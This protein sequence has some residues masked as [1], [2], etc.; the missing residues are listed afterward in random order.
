MA[1]TLIAAFFLFALLISEE[2][3]DHISPKTT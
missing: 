2:K 1:T 3:M